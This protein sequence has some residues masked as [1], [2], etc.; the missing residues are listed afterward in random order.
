[1]KENIKNSEEEWRDIPNYEGS[2]QVSSLGR[3]KSLKF[4]KEKLIAHHKI[5]KYLKVRLSK[6]GKIE[7]VYIHE[8]VMIA[9]V[10]SKPENMIILHANDVGTDNRIYNLSYDFRFENVKDK[11][12]IDP[13]YK[14][15]GK[16]LSSYEACYV[17]MLW[18]TGNVSIKD[19]SIMFKVDYMTIYDCINYKTFSWLSIDNQIAASITAI[20]YEGLFANK[21]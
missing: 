13:N 14:K 12:R 18:N 6:Q 9:F 16:G 3:V 17:R 15:G 10:G 8:L 21:M 20:K 5:G 2:Y 7:Q 19:M 1:M 11:Y 4:G